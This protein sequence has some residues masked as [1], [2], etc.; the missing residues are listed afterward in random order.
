MSIA[1]ERRELLRLRAEHQRS[2]DA[3]EETTMIKQERERLR[4]ATATSAP[5][6]DHLPRF[7]EAQ[8]RRSERLGGRAERPSDPDVGEWVEDMRCHLAGKLMS[9]GAACALIV[10]N[11]RFPGA[12]WIRPRISLWLL[13]E[14]ATTSHP[15][16]KAFFSTD[17]CQESLLLA[18]H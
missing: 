8:T 4:E 7:V 5:N 17:N 18:V 16:R 3:R 1:E 9:E 2:A 14:V 12:V 15:S 11:L 10:G 13:L 6:T